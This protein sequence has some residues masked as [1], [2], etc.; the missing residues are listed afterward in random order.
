[1]SYLQACEKQHGRR[2]AETGGGIHDSIDYDVAESFHLFE[3]EH[4]KIGGHVLSPAGSKVVMFR[5]HSRTRSFTT[6]VLLQ[7]QQQ[8]AAAAARGSG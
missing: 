8:Q 2:S 7:Q 5:M 1:M 4:R 3:S 6:K